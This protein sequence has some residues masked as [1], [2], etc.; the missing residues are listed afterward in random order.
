MS[1]RSSPYNATNV[2]P[3]KAIVAMWYISDV[4]LMLTYSHGLMND[5]IIHFPNGSH[6]LEPNY[7]ES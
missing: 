7:G 5:L 6:N 3:K 2:S 1:L 4:G